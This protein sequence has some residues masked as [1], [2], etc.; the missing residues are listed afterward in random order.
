MPADQALQHN[1]ALRH[2]L[3]G[4]LPPPV[5]SS[6]PLD[7]PDIRV[8]IFRQR[9]MDVVTQSCAHMVSVQLAGTRQMY[10]SRNG[11]ASTQLLRPG[12]V[13]VMPAGEPKHWRHAEE[14]QV[15]LMQL[16]VGVVDRIAAEM[17]DGECPG[18]RLRDDF[19]TCD[20]L[21]EQIGRRLVEEVRAPDPL[22]RLMAQSAAN[23][24]A[25]RL[26]RRYSGCAA[27]LAG[28]RLT[29]QKLRAA[30]DYIEAHLGEELTLAVIAQAIG[31]SACHFAHAFR[32]ETGL[33]PHR[34]VVQRRIERA[35][36]LLRETAL[37]VSEVGYRVGYPNQSHFSVAFQRVTGM[38][39]RAYREKA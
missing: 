10:Q 33:A 5:L 16:S 7:W 36:L 1:D 14:A 20:P 37:N 11:R 23:E 24:L 38:T 29:R 2:A 26:L 31:V 25:I 22:S 9:D 28:A 6:A 34:Y 13:I 17:T 27:P 21:I 3:R 39:P 35:R 18:P 12:A 4:V 30:T 8:E 32:R 19:G 15:L